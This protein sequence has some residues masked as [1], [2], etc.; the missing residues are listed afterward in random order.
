V[1]DSGR[2]NEWLPLPQVEGRCSWT[3]FSQLTD[4][5]LD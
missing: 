5:L 1:I 2:K 3:Y 4:R